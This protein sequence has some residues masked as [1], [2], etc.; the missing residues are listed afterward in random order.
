MFP[1]EVKRKSKDDDR[2]DIDGLQLDCERYTIYD[3]WYIYYYYY[4]FYIGHIS[5]YVRHVV[6]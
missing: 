5:V 2:K 6:A 3:K 4:Y 1:Q